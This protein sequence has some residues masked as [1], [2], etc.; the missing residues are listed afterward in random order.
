MKQIVVGLA[1]SISVCVSALK[2]GLL[3][4]LHLHVRY[5][6][7]LGPRLDGEGDCMPGSGVES[8][9]KAPLGR[10]GCD[11]PLILIDSMLSRLAET[12]P[13]LDVILMTGDFAGHHIA[14]QFGEPDIEKTYALLLETLGYLN[15]LIAYKFPNT[16]ILPAFGNNDSKY[17]DAPI[18]IDDAPFFYTYV[19]NLWFK[20]LPGNSKHLTRKQLTEV[21]G[22]FESGGYYRVDLNEKISVLSINTLY[23]DSERKPVKKDKNAKSRAHGS[24]STDNQSGIEQMFWLAEQLKGAEPERKFIII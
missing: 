19:F 14:M 20:L 13:D 11:C 24:E 22:T 6:Q 10:Y 12:Q 8:I 16:I 23:Y 1:L 3:S 9:I 7:N 21:L 15:E 4:D 2:V 5:D 17:H 18:P